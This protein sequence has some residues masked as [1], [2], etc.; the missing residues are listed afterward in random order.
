MTVKIPDSLPWEM[1]SGGLLGYFKDGVQWT[2]VATV[3]R[4]PEYVRRAINSYPALVEA[5]KR[6]VSVL[7]EGILDLDD[8]EA[9]HE[10]ALAALKAAGVEL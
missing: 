3:H 1:T 7:D 6:L 2:H 5:L 4:H 9:E 8:I 10:K